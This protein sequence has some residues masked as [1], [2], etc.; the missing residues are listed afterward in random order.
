MVIASRNTL[1][2]T[3]ATK[4]EDGSWWLVSADE[5]LE[6]EVLDLIGRTV[7]QGA[8]ES[9]KGLLLDLSG[10]PGGMYLL[11][12]RTLNGHVMSLRLPGASAYGTSVQA[13][14]VP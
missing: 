3:T 12:L 13:A 5:P 9:G 7:E 11:V 8:A 1:G 4:L 14:Q 6:W 2:R 10:Q